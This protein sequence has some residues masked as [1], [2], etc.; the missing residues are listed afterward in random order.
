M[1]GLSF[2]LVNQ[3]ADM[4]GR[5]IHAVKLP[6]S[7]DWIE[8]QSDHLVRSF[9][10]IDDQS[11]QM[12]ELPDWIDHRRLVQQLPSPGRDPLAGLDRYVDWWL[13]PRVLGAFTAT[14]R[15]FR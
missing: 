12:M 2:N 4:I 9:D 5:S 15:F 8:A 3:P 6:G 11:S 10:W 13:P 7:L 14:S 1:T